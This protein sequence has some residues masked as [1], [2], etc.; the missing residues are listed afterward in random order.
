M[1]GRLT[2]VKRSVMLWCMGQARQ[3]LIERQAAVAVARAAG[4]QRPPPA[5]DARV[6]ALAKLRSQPFFSAGPTSPRLAA[7]D[8][9]RQIEAERQALADDMAGVVRLGRT[10][11]CTWA[12]V[13]T[14]VGITRQAARERWHHLDG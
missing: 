14:A 5:P 4:E 9:L 12:E 10:A 6:S 3:R 13:G 11:G 7:L 8:A 1:F 2:D